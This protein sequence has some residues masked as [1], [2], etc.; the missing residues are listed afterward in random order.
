[1]DGC[2]APEYVEGHNLSRRCHFS[3]AMSRAAVRT[4]G[5]QIIPKEGSTPVMEIQRQENPQLQHLLRT[6][7]V[8]DTFNKEFSCGGGLGGMLSGL[9][10]MAAR[11]AIEE[12]S[13]ARPSSPDPTGRAEELFLAHQP[14]LTRIGLEICL[15]QQRRDYAAASH[16]IELPPP[17]SSPQAR[18]IETHTISLNVSDPEL[19]L[20]FFKSLNPSD[21]KRP[22]AGRALEMLAHEVDQAIVR[23]YTLG[24]IGLGEDG[25]DALYATAEE[26]ASELARLSLPNASTIMTTHLSHIW[27]GSLD[28]Y[29]AASNASILPARDGYMPHS[30]H[31]DCTPELYREKW[32]RALEALERVAENPRAASL[33]KECFEY[34]AGS[35]D[36]ASGHYRGVSTNPEV[37]LLYRERVPLFMEILTEASERLAQLRRF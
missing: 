20:A 31:L 37:P 17:P 32:G 30:W 12:I 36:V 2:G 19:L 13:S 15:D 28:E 11:G 21:V 3:Q 9:I 8:V 29:L 4:C 23:H 26:L 18:E 5:W 7:S 1:M 14:P 22:E 35:V 33:F 6:M 25:A 24:R 34:L 27:Q 16:A 10:S